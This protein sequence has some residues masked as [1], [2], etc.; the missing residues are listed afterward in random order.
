MTK[1]IIQNSVKCNECGDE[2]YSAHRHDFV[3]CTCGNI[4]V[5]GGTD[6]LRR[7]GKNLKNVTDTSMTMDKDHLRELVDAVNWAKETGRNEL[8][9]ALAVV[10]AL[11]KN[12]YLNEEAFGD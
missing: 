9:T 3:T 11:R 12:G 8:G 6:Y 2:I 5:D 10:R 1:R 7:S 4:S